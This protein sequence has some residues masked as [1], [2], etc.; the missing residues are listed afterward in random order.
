MFP[1]RGTLCVCACPHCI[2]RHHTGERENRGHAAAASWENPSGMCSGTQFP[3]EG[4]N[5]V[6]SGC[7]LRSWCYFCIKAGPLHGATDLPVWRVPADPSRKGISQERTGR[8][9]WQ[10]W[11]CSQGQGQQGAVRSS[12]RAEPEPELSPGTQ[13]GMGRRAGAEIRIP[14]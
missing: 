13:R 9:G 3:V 10:C 1:G 7:R 8:T 4:L 2:S 14:N 5:H 12:L 6:P 11:G